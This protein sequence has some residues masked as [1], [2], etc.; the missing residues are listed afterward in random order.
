LSA[1]AALAI[2]TLAIGTTAA[3]AG[4]DFSLGSMDVPDSHG[5]EE[6]GILG[7][8]WNPGP[9]AFRFGDN[10]APGSATW[11]IMGAGLRDVSGFDREHGLLRTLDITAL[12]VP[13]FDVADYAATFDAAFNVWS[14]VALIDN[15]GQVA[16]GGANSG[17]SPALG[18]HLGDIRIAAWRILNPNVLAHALQPGGTL[19]GDIHF[20]TDFDWVDEPTD[21]GFDLDIDLFTVAVHEFGHALGLDH[22]DV[23]GSVMNPFYSGGRRTL[24]ADDIAGIQ[25]IYGPR[26]AADLVP[27]P[28]SIIVFA[29]CGLFGLV[30]HRRR[31]RAS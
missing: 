29:G 2:G 6:F 8:A 27:E 25:S 13:G 30:L 31:K 17:A 1:C 11:S 23:F 26:P 28:T 20:N 21:T 22:S 16:D 24:T 4:M 3:Q 9:N 14:A 12:G 15:L 5:P 18:G 10:P 7:T 19:G